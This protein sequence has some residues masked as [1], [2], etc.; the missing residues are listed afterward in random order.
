MRVEMQLSHSL[1][2]RALSPLTTGT[3]YNI[4]MTDQNHS[5]QDRAWQ[6]NLIHLRPHLLRLGRKFTPSQAALTSAI[7]IPHS[8]LLM[9]SRDCQ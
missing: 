5:P 2:S 6:H 3:L 1:V 4:V 8:S 9:L 7:H